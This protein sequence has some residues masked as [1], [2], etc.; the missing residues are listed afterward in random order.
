VRRSSTRRDNGQSRTGFTNRVARDTDQVATGVDPYAL[1]WDMIMPTTAEA[2]TD[3]RH[4][5]TRCAGRPAP[6][7]REAIRPADPRATFDAPARRTRHTDAAAD[8]A[9]HVD[10]QPVERSSRPLVSLAFRRPTRATWA[11]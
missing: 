7:S 8:C 9:A 10:L 5:Q 1:S 11:R 3:A 6:C 2:R 4:V